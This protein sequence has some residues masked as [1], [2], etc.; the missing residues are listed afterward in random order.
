M[1]IFNGAK[2][3]VLSKSDFRLFSDFERVE[4]PDKNS[5]YGK[6]LIELA[7]EALQQ[8][9]PQLYAS[10]YR[11]FT[12]NGNRQNYEKGYCERRNMLK[13]LLTGEIIQNEERYIDKIIDLVWLILEETTWIIPAHNLDRSGRVGAPN[14]PLGKDF[15]G[16]VSCVDLCSA[17]TGALLS[18][19]YY[20]LEDKLD[21]ATPIICDR[22]IYEMR[23]KVLQP[24]I[25]F[26]DFWWMGLNP[27]RRVNNWNP[28]ISANVLTVTALTESDNRIRQHVLDK[29]M[30]CMDSFVNCYNPDGGCNEGP[31]YWSHAG[32]ALFMA[33]ELIYDMTGGEADYFGEEIIFNMMDYIRK[34]HLQDY[35]YANFADCDAQLY[36]GGLTT[37]A[38][39]GLRTKN[40][41]LVDFAVANTT[42]AYIPGRYDLVYQ[43]LK[44]FCFKMPIRKQ[45]I[46]NKFDILKDLQV[47]IYR[48]KDGFSLAAKGGHNKESHNHND[49]GQIIVLNAGEPVFIDIGSP[50]YTRDVFNENRYNVFPIN[51]T[52]HNL[53]VINGYGQKEGVEFFCDKFLATE[54]KIVIE[55]QSSY[56]KHTGVKKCIREIVPGKDSVIINE[57]I[58]F[59][60]SEAI[61]QYYMVDSPVKIDENTF[62]LKNG[63]SITAPY[64]SEIIPVPIPDDKLKSIWETDTL[65]KLAVKVTKDGERKIT[66]VLKRC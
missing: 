47:A 50:L 29:A 21:K 3:N 64:G 8:E 17:E 34:V 28:W 44:N 6:K 52:W 33:L 13:K 12:Q 63:V 61:F 57:T 36:R 31:S 55:Y 49:V 30:E 22:I 62:V 66:L 15:T 27:G 14:Q 39:M 42:E 25:D 1:K 11:Q 48:N 4:F 2:Y 59:E 24:Y 45:Y 23:R 41:M 16:K 10:I 43:D 58:D 32:G 9:I 40:D 51:S 37:V 7:N 54:E 26:Y 60:G 56:E 65:Y 18:F 53:P 46:P 38:R 35:R 19:V 20:F 5:E